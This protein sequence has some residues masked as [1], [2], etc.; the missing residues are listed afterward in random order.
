MRPALSRF[1][2]GRDY[3]MTCFGL[4][5]SFCTIVSGALQMRVTAKSLGIDQLSLA[6]RILLVEEIWDSIAT[7]T[8]ALD[9][10]QGHKDELDRRLASYHADPSAG[11]SW[12]NVKA[13]L[14]NP[15]ETA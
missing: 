5:A 11:S 10:P 9:V 4:R 13:R 15:P 6:E 12:E 2:A 14:G 3:F 8:E 7:E 1:Y